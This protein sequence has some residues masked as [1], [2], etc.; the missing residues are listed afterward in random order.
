MVKKWSSAGSHFRKWGYQPV[1]DICR[2]SFWKLLRYLANIKTLFCSAT[3]SFSC[4]KCL[5]F[6]IVYESSI[7]TK[8][9]VVFVCLSVG[10]WRGNGNPNPY[11]DLDEILLTHPHVFKE[12][13]GA[14][15]TLVFYPACAWGIENPIGWRTH[16]FLQNKRC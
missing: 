13:F 2:F 15:I 5:K 12:G 4:K 9:G 11:T 14:S 7:Y 16:F 1:A 8:M 6:E 3:K 10:T